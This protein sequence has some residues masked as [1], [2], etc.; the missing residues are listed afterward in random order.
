MGNA[1]RDQGARLEEVLVGFGMPGLGMVQVSLWGL[2]LEGPGEVC[3]A[4]MGSLGC[5]PSGVWGA[6]LG[7]LLRMGSAKLG[8]SQE[9][10]VC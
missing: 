6:E 5:G 3:G 1:V 9:S 8:T 7:I 4:V 2:R 10:L